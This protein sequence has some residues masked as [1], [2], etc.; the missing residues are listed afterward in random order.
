MYVYIYIYIY[1][2]IHIYIK[3]IN[4]IYVVLPYYHPRWPKRRSF[5]SYKILEN[6]SSSSREAAV[7]SEDRIVRDLLHIYQN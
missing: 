5:V 4:I 7:T 3:Y 2:Y 6:E 1:T